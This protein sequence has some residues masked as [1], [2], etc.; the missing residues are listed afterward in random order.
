MAAA[1]SGDTVRVH[2]TGTLDD[3][4]VFDS[5]QGREPLEFT[6]G[7]GQVIPGFDEAVTGMQPGDE[8][9]VTIPSGEAYGERRPEMLAT[10]PRSQ[11]PPEIEPEI[12]Q[13]LQVSQDGQNFVVTI[14]EVGDDQVTLDANH[15]LAGQDLTFRL[16]L[17]EI[18]GE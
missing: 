2:Y 10:V 11:F 15:P 9:T 12:G 1:K 7:I 17:V 6:V 3:G 5:S 8:K 14:V 18:V 16:E 4:S 13:Q